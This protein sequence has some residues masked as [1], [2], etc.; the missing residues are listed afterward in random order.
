MQKKRIFAD[1][2]P[3]YDKTLP[4]FHLLYSFDAGILC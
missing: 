3:Q 4:L 1:E 2:S